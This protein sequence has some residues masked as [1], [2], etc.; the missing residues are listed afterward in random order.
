[1]QHSEGQRPAIDPG[2]NTRRS[3]SRGRPC[4]SWGPFPPDGPAPQDMGT[5]A[6]FRK[7]FWV[8]A[9]DDGYMNTIAVQRRKQNPKRMDASGEPA[10]ERHQSRR[11]RPSSVLALAGA[12]QLVRFGGSIHTCRGCE[13]QAPERRRSAPELAP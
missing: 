10:K 9:L 6:Q 4:R 5:K 3:G 13:H 11:I 7:G 2:V 8:H 12:H 1:M